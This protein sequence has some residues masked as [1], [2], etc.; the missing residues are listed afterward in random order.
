MFRFAIYKLLKKILK[1]IKKMS[2]EMDELRAEVA[3]NTEGDASAILLIQRMADKIDELANNPAE[4]RAF[5]AE[6]RASRERLASS[7]FENTPQEP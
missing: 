5:A 3:A 1:E 2:I 6:L 7:V 4:L